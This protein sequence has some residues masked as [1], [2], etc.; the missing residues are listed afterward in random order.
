MSAEAQAAVMAKTMAALE[1]G[2][3]RPDVGKT[4]PLDQ[5]KD[6][7]AE[8]LKEARGGKVLLRLN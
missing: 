4:F 6:A 3:M 7:V 2:V 1:A 5:Y 8:S